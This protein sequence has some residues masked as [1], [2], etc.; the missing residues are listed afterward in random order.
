MG[1]EASFEQHNIK[2][3]RRRQGLGRYNMVLTPGKMKSWLET[4][5]YASFTKDGNDK[6]GR[7]ACHQSAV[8]SPGIMRNALA[9]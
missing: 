3:D 9:R 1:L 5:Q 2:L 8:I 7:E 4:R 6:T